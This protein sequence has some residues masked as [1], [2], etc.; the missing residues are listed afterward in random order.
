MIHCWGLGAFLFWEKS[1]LRRPAFLRMQFSMWTS[2]A[3]KF[4]S[5]RMGYRQ[6]LEIQLSIWFIKLMQTGDLVF[7]LWT[8]LPEP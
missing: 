2:T 3:R 7:F 6:I 8:L 1:T 5:L 4:I